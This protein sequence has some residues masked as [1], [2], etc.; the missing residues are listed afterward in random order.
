M[1]EEE[2]VR[3]LAVE[4]FYRVINDERTHTAVSI[5]GLSLTLEDGGEFT[6]V[7]IPYDVAEAIK[8]LND[9]SIPPRRQSIYTFLASHEEFKEMIGRTLQRVIIDEVD[10]NTGLY[11]ATVEFKESGIGI[12]IKMVP[13]QAIY[14]ALITG[15]PIYVT[16]RLVE[17]ERS[18]SK[19]EG[20]GEEEGG[21]GEEGEP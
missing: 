2:L 20:E 9:G 7:N 19:E 4:P 12:S 21:E 6:L 13:S 15:K 8:I 5:V 1:S 14:L 16:R 3:V 18:W 17:L 11:T 10:L